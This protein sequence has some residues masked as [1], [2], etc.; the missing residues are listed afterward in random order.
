MVFDNTSPDPFESLVPPQEESPPPPEAGSNPAPKANDQSIQASSAPTNQ[1]SDPFEALVPQQQLGTWGVL[2]EAG[3][4]GLAEGLTSA[5]QVLTPFEDRPVDQQE[6]DQ[7]SQLLAQPISQGWSDP[8]WWASHIAHGA[9]SSSPALATGAAG[10]MLGSEAGPIGTLV[11]G[12]GGYALGTAIQ[13]VAPAYQR[14][15]ADGLSHDDAVDRAI[16]ET[17]IASAFAG[18]MG[19]APGASIFGTTVEG[20]VKRPLSEALAQI[21]GVQPSLGIAQQEATKLSQ[22]KGNITPEEAAQSYAEQASSGAALVGGHTLVSGRNHLSGYGKS[23]KEATQKTAIPEDKPEEQP[24]QSQPSIIDEGTS[25]NIPGNIGESRQE[26]EY[27]TREDPFEAL[28]PKDQDK[29]QNHQDDQDSVASTSL[30]NQT[31]KHDIDPLGYYSQALDAAQDLKQNKGTPQQMIA[32]LKKA[33]VKD[34]EIDAT[35]LNQFLDGKKIVSKDDIVQHLQDNRIAVNETTYERDNDFEDVA[36]Q[37]LENWKSEINNSSELSEVSERHNIFLDSTSA[38][39]PIKDFLHEQGVP[40]DEKVSDNFDLLDAIREAGGNIATYEVPIWSDHHGQ[41]FVVEAPNG[42]TILLPQR[43]GGESEVFDS[44]KSALE[45]LQRSASEAAEDQ[46]HEDQDTQLQYYKDQERLNGGFKDNTK[47]ADHSLDPENPTYRETVL[48]LPSDNGKTQFQSGHFAQPNIIG[49]MMSSMVKDSEGNRVFNVDQI[50]S[51]WGQKLRDKGVRD[52][53]KVVELRRLVEEANKREN[54]AN[55]SLEEYSKLEAPFHSP[56]FDRTKWRNEG[57]TPEAR[58]AAEIMHEWTNAKNEQQRLRAELE[59][60]EASAPGNPLVN[61]TDQWVNTTLRRAITQAVESGADKIAIPSGDTVLSYNPG[62]TEGMRGFYDKIVP[63]NLKNILRK[64]DPKSPDPEH[65][66]KL[67]TPTEG[68]K[69][70]G[71]TLFP[72][73][74]AVRAKVRNEGQQMFA[75]GGAVKKKV[76]IKET[77]KDILSDLKLARRYKVK[78]LERALTRELRGLSV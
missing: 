48:H 19:L 58:R 53:A 26:T 66:G 22:G 37:N 68:E 52:D 14:A 21:F 31:T 1:Q 38:F 5:G 8:K 4:R 62:D 11:G 25:K 43:E 40:I 41:W 36:R 7:V 63:K 9:A 51:D 24:L 13:T 67:V 71:F 70:N 61:T 2:K 30:E 27:S 65:V 32:Q 17:G 15:R 18:G 23:D 47:W 50:Q 60:A 78:P 3:R 29:V 54:N 73:T 55:L 77:R 64:L 59:T 34:A 10:S 72:I 28:V 6:Q 39:Y 35:G 56:D 49:H 74:D 76:E 57:E 45:F 42:N 20:A 33:G 75:S 12:A 44:K 46:I 16:K 69:G